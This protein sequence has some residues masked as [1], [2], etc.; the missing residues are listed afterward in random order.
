MS[1]PV[2]VFTNPRTSAPSGLPPM[3]VAHLTW[4]Q[5]YHPRALKTLAKTA[6]G[7]A[8]HFDADHRQYGP[9]EAVADLSALEAAARRAPSTDGVR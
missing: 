1:T 3:L 5:T 8:A 4:L 9:P 7:M 6:A 2:L